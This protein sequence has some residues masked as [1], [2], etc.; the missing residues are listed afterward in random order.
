MKTEQ[1]IKDRIKLLAQKDDLPS[2]IGSLMLLWVLDTD[3]AKLESYTS[4]IVNGLTEIANYVEELNQQC[5]PLDAP[6]P[7]PVP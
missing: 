7:L 6:E 3:P 2:L 1:E 4:H 5:Q